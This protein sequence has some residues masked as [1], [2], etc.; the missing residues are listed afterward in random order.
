MFNN[1]NRM[2]VPIT[3]IFNSLID[4]YEKDTDTSV[5]TLYSI[6]SQKDDLIQNLK[7]TNEGLSGI[8]TK[9][10]ANI[11]KTNKKVT[12]VL[13]QIS[14]N[15]D[16]YQI[17]INQKN[18]KSKINLLTEH[19][20]KLTNKLLTSNA[21]YNNLKQTYFGLNTLYIDKFNSAIQIHTDNSILENKISML[22][23]KLANTN[24]MFK[25]QICFNNIIDIII[26]PC[27][28][29]YICKECVEQIIENTDD[30]AVV[31]CPVCNEQIMEY[32]NIYLPI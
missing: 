12:H 32:K 22:E 5:D 1:S 6:I 30:N 24:N 25:C 29:I 20:K 19:K 11:D 3:N 10:N 15:Q 23:D 8:I 26:M 4:T 9:F 28:H 21:N 16:I 18:L 2:A 13:S 27:F 7:D 31:N 17:M 14:T